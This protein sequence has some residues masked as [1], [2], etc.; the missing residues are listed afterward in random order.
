M[1]DTEPAPAS[2]ESETL[3]VHPGDVIQITDQK[4]VGVGCF[5]L[6]E[7]CYKW[8]I[9][10]TLHWLNSNQSGAMQ[11]YHRLRPGQFAVVGAAAILT[12]DLLAAR[13]DSVE[14]ARLVAQEAA[15]GQ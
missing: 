1:A 12:P 10:A 9:G 7:G 8:G 15:T 3:V 4:H 6:V 14:T 13:R 5:L 2:E 11:S